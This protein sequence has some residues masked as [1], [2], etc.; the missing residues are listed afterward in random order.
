MPSLTE[1]HLYVGHSDHDGN[2][3]LVSI[4]KLT[5]QSTDYVHLWRLES[6]IA[7]NKQVQS[8]IIRL[9]RTSLTVACFFLYM[10]KLGLNGDSTEL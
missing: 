10:Q 3:K 7:P 8:S 6:D 5:N 4:D 9:D 2:K 1:L